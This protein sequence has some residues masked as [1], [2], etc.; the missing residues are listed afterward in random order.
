MK[1]CLYLFPWLQ[2]LQVYKCISKTSLYPISWQ[3]ND[4]GQKCI[5]LRS[6]CLLIGSN[7]PVTEKVKRTYMHH[8]YQANIQQCYEP[9]KKKVQLLNHLSVA[10]DM[11][12]LKRKDD[13]VWFLLKTL[14]PTL[15]SRVPTWAAYNSLIGNL[16]PL[17]CAAML[18]VIN[19]SSTEQ[20]NLHTAIKE[21]EKLR[22]CVWSDGKIVIS[23]D[24]ELYIKAIRL[25]QKPDIRDNFVFRMGEL[26]VVFCAHNV[27][28]KF[29]DSNGLDQAFVEAG[30]YY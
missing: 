20:Q 29:I 26:P 12:E 25:Q 14:S 13:L 24:L 28:G 16:R 6:S 4:L 10:T 27:L 15:S 8:D 1:G 9:S 3:C 7:A 19:G 2:G 21:A 22:Q 11:T 5:I 23:F 30:S 18:P 17:T